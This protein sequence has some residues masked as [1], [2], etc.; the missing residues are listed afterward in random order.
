MTLVILSIGSNVQPRQN[1]AA[2]LDALLQTFGDMSVSRLYESQPVGL[3]H[4]ETSAN[5]YNLVVALT[6]DWPVG[7]LQAHFKAL[8]KKQGRQ[9]DSHSKQDK[10]TSIVQPLDLD[11]LSVGQLVGCHDGVELPRKDIL[12]HAFVLRPLAELLPAQRHPL[13]QR[14]Y[15]ELWQDFNAATQPLWPVAF[16]WRFELPHF[17]AT[18]C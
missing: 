15:A 3:R 2:C 13:T 8:E 16:A 5:F 9:Q 10:Q 17:S 11:L 18:L 12:H 4:G 7:Q 1:I 14:R 6:S